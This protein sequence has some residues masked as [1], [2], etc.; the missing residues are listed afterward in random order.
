M[1]SALKGFQHDL[2][3][4]VRD[5]IIFCLLETSENIRNEKK[6]GLRASW[7]VL[8]PSVKCCTGT[9]HSK[10][11]KCDTRATRALYCT[12]STL[13]EAMHLAGHISNMKTFDRFLCKSKSPGQTSTSWNRQ[14]SHRLSLK[15]R[16]QTC[17]HHNHTSTPAMHLTFCRFRKLSMTQKKLRSQREQGCKAIW[18]IGDFQPKRRRSSREVEVFREDISHC[19]K[20]GLGNLTQPCQ[21]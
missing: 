5:I 4:L 11:T 8:K 21:T 7:F 1:Q 13:C 20:H 15:F 2:T 10:E 9:P 14:W 19:G 6:T 16:D 3:M 12:V 18:D 17:T